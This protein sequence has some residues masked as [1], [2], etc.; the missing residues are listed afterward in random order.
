MMSM[1][2][3][4]D[5]SKSSTFSTASSSGGIGWDWGNIFDSSDFNSISGNGSEGRLGTWS[6]GLVSCSSS[7][8][9]LDV[10]GGDAQLFKSG[11]NVDG[12]HHGSVGR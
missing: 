3:N 12:S 2:L 1:M 8:S 11:N 7:G 4:I 10:N 6:W 5:K 9:E